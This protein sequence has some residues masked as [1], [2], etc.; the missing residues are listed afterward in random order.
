MTLWVHWY[1][2]ICLI[3][4]AFSHQSTFLWFALTVMGFTVRTDQLGIT[5]IVRALALQSRCYQSL[6]DHFQS[7]SI[8]LDRLGVLWSRC[9]LQLFG[10]LTERVNGRLVVLGDGKK[11]AK[12]GR[13]M[14]GVKCLHQ[15][16]E[17]NS[18]PAWIMGHSCQA[19]SLLVNAAS[20]VFAVPLDMK[21]HEGTI[22]SN[23]S[24]QTL[25]DKM[26]QLIGSLE[27]PE[28]FYFVA[29]SYYASGKIIKG[30]L[31]DGNHLITRCRSNSV[32]CFP[33]P[34][35]AGKRGRGRPR[36]YGKKV[37]LKNLFQ[38]AHKTSYMSSPIYGEKN[39][40][41][42]VKS[43][44]LLW[45]SA[46]RL[47]KFVLVEHPERGRWILLCTDR[48]LEVREVIR[49]YGLRFKIELGFKQAAE[50][51][52]AFQY[53]F[54]MKAM[55]RIK[56]RGG[57]QY[58]HKETERYRQGVR[59]KIHSYHVHL[60]AGIVAQGL[61][62]YLSACHT[63]LVWQSFGSWLRTIRAG[64]APSER[65]VS[66]SLRNT[67]CEFLLVNAQTNKLAKFIVERQD[68]SR[69]DILGFAA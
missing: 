47:V 62:Q 67:L 1:Q 24:K 55:K 22:I 2:A 56:R 27:L 33:A 29:D 64:V 44:E 69:A 31:K 48:E 6:L 41:I 5:S 12:Q 15:E 51:V 34:T 38:S 18:K 40:T 13:K 10:N 46:S 11:I 37:A 17:N 61:M 39:V 7:Q 53:H 59:R 52:G 14:P 66:I 25:L 63:E 58:L 4:P 36:Q 35:V 45:G 28:N 42:K 16:S 50:V 19:V 30:M 57:N 43:F 54:W 32:A 26:L 21:I 20:S 65:V 68:R 3:R 49:L 8:K 23:R 9:V 60:F